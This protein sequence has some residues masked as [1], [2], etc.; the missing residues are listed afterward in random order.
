MNEH[1]IDGGKVLGANGGTLAIVNLTNF[2]QA[3]ELALMT[4]T[5]VWTILKIREMLAQKNPN[6]K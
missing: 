5:L 1:L 2:G 4:A 6:K 3:L